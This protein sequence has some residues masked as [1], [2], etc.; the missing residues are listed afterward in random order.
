[1]PPQNTGT[2]MSPET[3]SSENIEVNPGSGNASLQRALNREGA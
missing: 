1:M 3:I 2:G